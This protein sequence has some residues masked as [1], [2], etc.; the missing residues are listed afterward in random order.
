[1]QFL[2]EQGAKDVLHDA[3]VAVVIRLT[4]GIDSNLCSEGL[5]PRD[6]LDTRRYSTIIESSDTFD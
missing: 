1:M 2:G 5:L 6:Y 4:R 3:S